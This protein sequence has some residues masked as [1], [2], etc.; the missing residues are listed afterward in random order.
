MCAAIRT[1][2]TEGVA[3]HQICY[4]NPLCTGGQENGF[5]ARVAGAIVVAGAILADPKLGARVE[6]LEEQLCQP[7]C[8]PCSVGSVDP[9]IANGE[10]VDSPHRTVGALRGGG[11]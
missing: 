7:E 10:A 1:A 2:L 5:A 6:Q 9:D 3:T 8:K 4:L 11:R